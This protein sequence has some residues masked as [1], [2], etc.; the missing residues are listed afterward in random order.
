MQGKVA[1]IDVGK[2]VVGHVELPVQ[3]SEAFH[4]DLIARAVLAVQS[5]SRQ[6]YGTDPE[7]GKGYSAKLSRRR[8]NF[9]GAYG[10]GISRVPRKTMRRRGTQFT[11]VGALS[12]NTVG[13]RQAHPPKAVKV[14]AKKVNKKEN[15]KAIRSALAATLAVEVVRQRGHI[16]PKDY[17]FVAASGLED[18]AK[19]KEAVNALEK[20]GF[21]N[22]LA[23]VARR[24]VRAGKGKSRGRKYRMKKGPL[25]VVSKENCSLLRS[26]RNIMGVDIAVV[27]RLNANLLAPGTSP[28]RLTLFTA[29]AIERLGKEKLFT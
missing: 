13:G 16:M 2:G 26:A 21:G 5:N 28:G 18:L 3:F 1:V 24:S 10:K 29:A 12:P 11:W 19:T 27:N 22:D 17:P 7:A 15:R 4:P 23:R 14:W 6:P 9:K 25:I 8:R 20:L